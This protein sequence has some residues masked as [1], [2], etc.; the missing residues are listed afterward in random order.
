MTDSEFDERAAYTLAEIEQAVETS[1]ADIDFETVSEVLTLEFRD[2]SKI[3]VN[4]QAPVH[5]IWVA[6]RSGGFHYRFDAGRNGW[7]NCQTGSDLFADL[8][9]LAGRQAGTAVTFRH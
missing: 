7:V 9:E 8:S 5:E 6:A 4:K 3:I 1:G 2:G